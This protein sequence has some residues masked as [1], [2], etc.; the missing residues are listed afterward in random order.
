MTSSKPEI[1]RDAPAKWYFET[2]M[3]GEPESWDEVKDRPE[4]F[5]SAEAAYVFAD[6]LL[7]FLRSRYGKS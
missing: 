3:S 5:E 6:K 7:T 1:D 4:F 2:E